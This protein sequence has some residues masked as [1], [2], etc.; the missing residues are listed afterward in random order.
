MDGG[1][2]DPAFSSAAVLVVTMLACKEY[3]LI[4]LKELSKYEYFFVS[5]SVF[6]VWWR[7]YL[8]DKKLDVVLYA[9]FFVAYSLIVAWGKLDSN[10][11]VIMLSLISLLVFGVR[12][13]KSM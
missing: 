1:G 6:I 4:D 5:A 3:S 8:H 11:L 13:R 10:V 9:G 2:S 12:H 7:L